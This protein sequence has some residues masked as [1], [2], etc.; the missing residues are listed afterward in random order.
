MFNAVRL[1]SM[2]THK[3][4]MLHS[5][6]IS[7]ARLV[8]LTKLA[9]LAFPFYQWVETNFRDT[10]DTKETLDTILK[11]ADALNVKRA[12]RAC[13]S[14]SNE[15]LPLL[16]DGI[17]RPYEHNK[18][19]FYFFSWMVRDAPQQRLSPL[20]N[21][22]R[23]ETKI[24]KV[25]LEI[26]AISQLLVEYRDSIQS[27]EW[28]AVREVICDRL[29]GSRRSIRGRQKEVI[30][31]TAVLGAVQ[32]FYAQHKN[33]GI[34]KKVDVEPKE[35]KLG[36]ETFDVVVDLIAK[37]LNLSTKIGSGRTPNAIVKHRVTEDSRPAVTAFTRKNIVKN[38][39]IAPNGRS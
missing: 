21:R 16:F 15:E 6:D 33:Y 25:D 13:Y 8:E 10:L 11:Q 2:S 34:Y 31:R 19:C 35:V 23:R 39:T 14:P 20:I 1:T 9:D 17:G 38:G 18:A 26:E 29:E 4:L 27:F 3:K 24:G 32:H 7:H 30:V 5:V 22:A 36:Y 37:Q 28:D 12:L